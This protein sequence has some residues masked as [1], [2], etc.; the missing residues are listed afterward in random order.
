MSFLF[1]KIRIQEDSE[2]IFLHHVNSIHVLKKKLHDLSNNQ[3]KPH[4]FEN[5][6]K[7][8]LQELL[9]KE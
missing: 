6:T 8:K 7:E 1:A 5:K 9:I 4:M 2:A 3:V